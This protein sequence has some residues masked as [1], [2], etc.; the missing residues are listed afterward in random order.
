[1]I[2]ALREV[3]QSVA[4]VAVSVVHPPGMNRNRD[5]E[6]S[7]PDSHQPSAGATSLV[8]AVSA[9]VAGFQAVEKAANLLQLINNLIALYQTMKPVLEK[10]GKVF[11]ALQDANGIL[12]DT[13]K[14]LDSLSGAMTGTLPT[15]TALGLDTLLGGSY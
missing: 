12:Q 11:T 5:R 4:G 7:R 8:T 15:G 6:V 14:D 10:L 3:V 13:H 9:I 1:M 2:K